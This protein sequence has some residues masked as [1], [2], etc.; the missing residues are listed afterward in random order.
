MKFHSS[1]DEERSIIGVFS[2]VLPCSNKGEQ[3]RYDKT[4]SILSTCSTI[5]DFP[6]NISVT[7]RVSDAFS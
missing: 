7:R 2:E 4:R 6:V 5:H 1:E 3:G